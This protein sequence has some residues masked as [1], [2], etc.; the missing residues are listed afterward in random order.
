VVDKDQPPQ[1]PF[2]RAAKPALTDSAVGENLPANLAAISLNRRSF[3]GEC[4]PRFVVFSFAASNVLE[5]SAVFQERS[6]RWP[7]GRVAATP[8]EV[9]G[10]VRVAD[11]TAAVCAAGASDA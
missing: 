4:Q 11:A 8:R 10:H 3:A 2:R 1:W 5:Q 7:A 6:R 9:L